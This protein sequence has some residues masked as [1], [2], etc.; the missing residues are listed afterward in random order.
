MTEYL[1]IYE[2]GRDGGGWSAYIPDVE[3][4][5]ALG[6]DR[7]EVEAR[8]REAMAARLADLREQGLELP[9]PVNTAGYVAA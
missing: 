5:F 6:D 3:G 2:S 8:M 9:Q 1:V 7:A 4:V